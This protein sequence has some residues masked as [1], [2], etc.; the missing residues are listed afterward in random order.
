VSASAAQSLISARDER[1]VRPWFQVCRSLEYFGRSAIFPGRAAP[2]SRALPLR[3][4]IRR[5][6]RSYLE[7]AM[8][9]RDAGQLIKGIGI[10]LL[11]LTWRM[12]NLA[13]ALPGRYP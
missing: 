5:F 11:V 9:G 1:C 2:K 6:S 13:E 3:D 8:L 10:S 7:S 4:V 12:P